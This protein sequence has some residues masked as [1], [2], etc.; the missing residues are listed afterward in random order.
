MQHTPQ[1]RN[2]VAIGGEEMA[3]IGQVEVDFPR[4]PGVF[5]AGGLGEKPQGRGGETSAIL[6][7]L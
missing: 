5:N 4:T 6:H 3:T 1:P 2:Y 7:S